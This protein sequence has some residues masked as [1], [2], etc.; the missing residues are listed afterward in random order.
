MYIVLSRPVPCP[1]CMELAY[2]VIPG[3]FWTCIF[4]S[5]ASKNVAPGNSLALQLAKLYQT[6]CGQN[7]I[8]SIIMSVKL[9][10]IIWEFWRKLFNFQ[11][12]EPLTLFLIMGD[13]TLWIKVSLTKVTRSRSEWISKYVNYQSLMSWFYFTLTMFYK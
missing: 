12:Q 13:V 11:L 1:Y 4:T 9:Q 10:V 2:R 8:Q 7:Y 3:P 6:K 5:V